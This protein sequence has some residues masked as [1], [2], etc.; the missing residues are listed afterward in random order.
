MKKLSYLFSLV[1]L[2]AIVMV[3]ACSKEEDPQPTTPDECAAA[4]FPATTGSATIK[5]LNFTKTQDGYTVI[6]ANANSTLAF[7]VEITKGTN[8]PQKLRV[9]QTDCKNAKG[10]IVTFTGQSGLE[11]GGKRFDLRNTDEAQVRNFN[12]TVPAGMATIYLNIETDESGNTYSYKR[13]KINVSGSG[14][15]DSYTGISLA[16]QANA[17][18]PSR[19]ASTTGQTYRA[20]D[21]YANIDYID[22]TYAFSNNGSGSAHFASNSARFGTTIAIPSSTANCGEDGTVDFANKG[23]RT[24]FKSYV[25]DFA[26]ATNTEI[27]AI[28]FSDEDGEVIP[29]TGAGTTYAFQTSNNRKG[30]IHVVSGTFTNTVN[31]TIVTNVKVQR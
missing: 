12:Y 7:A 8:R 25:G 24:K 19:L 31:A 18:V 11:D 26:S 6:E 10:E 17:T 5:I 13:V 16:P 4:E 28:T 2:A 30:L 27:A 22:I 21:A 29:V 20:C 9:Y 14:I 3:T 23:V 1:A 15:I